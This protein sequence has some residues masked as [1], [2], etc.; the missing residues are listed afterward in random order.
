MKIQL[1][2]VCFFLL[3]S[4]LQAQKGFVTELEYDSVYGIIRFKHINTIDSTVRVPAFDGLNNNFTVTYPNGEA[5]VSIGPTCNSDYWSLQPKQIVYRG[6]FLE[7]IL[8]VLTEG[9]R[10]NRKYKNVKQEMGIY[11]IEWIVE[12]QRTKTISIDYKG[13]LKDKIPRK[14]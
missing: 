13:G 11:K 2:A 7:D 6:G 4:Q 1:I 10:F 8:E 9:A 5:V 12:G 14:K 3:F